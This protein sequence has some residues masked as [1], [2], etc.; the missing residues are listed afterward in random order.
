MRCNE[1][2]QK[3]FNLEA[4]RLNNS[5]MANVSEAKATLIGLVTIVILLG[6]LGQVIFGVFGSTTGLGNKTANPDV[7]TS[8]VV[9]GS[10]I[11]VVVIVLVILKLVD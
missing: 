9:I 8:V 10:G 4:F 3:K 1:Y 5:G 7:P 6:A 11:V 2:M